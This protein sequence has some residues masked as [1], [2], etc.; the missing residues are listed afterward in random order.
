MRKERAL[1]IIKS[2]ISDTY[3]FRENKAIL[4]TLDFFLID[5]SFIE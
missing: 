3:L 4:K 2:Q 1:Q 5:N